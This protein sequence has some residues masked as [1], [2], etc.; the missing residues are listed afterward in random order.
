MFSA[1]LTAFLIE[2]KELLQQDNS[3]ISISLLLKIV[4]SQQRMEEG[5]VLRGL[6]PADIPPFSVPVSARWING[7]WFTALAMSLSAALV[8][9]LAKEWLTA[10]TTSRPRPAHTYSVLRQS[11]LEGLAHWRALHIINLLPSLLH[12]ALLLFSL[13]LVIYLWTLDKGIAGVVMG[14]TGTTLFFYVATSILGAVNEFCPFVTQ[15]SKYIQILVS[16]GA[17]NYQVSQTDP[18]VGDT[19]PNAE[20]TDRHLRALKWLADNARDPAIGDCAYQALAGL[21]I[22]LPEDSNPSNDSIKQHTLLHSFFATICQRLSGALVFRPQELAAC[23]GMNAARYAASLPK[24]L[25]YL[26]SHKGP[27]PTSNSGNKNNGLQLA[28]TLF[29]HLSFAD[30]T[31]YV[32]GLDNRRS[33]RYPLLIKSGA[34]N[35]RLSALTLMQFL[36]QQSSNSPQPLPRYIMLKLQG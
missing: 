12:V 22:S 21:R 23:Y 35:A 29:I 30:R 4:Q 34:T 6:P 26:E 14:I 33:Q 20:T 15:V 11:R 31:C 16:F 8:G 18:A 32:R 28:C 5:E 17:S 10:F 7:L 1:I 36:P 25:Q 19:P 2:S 27:C 9:L 3:D 24:M 13:G